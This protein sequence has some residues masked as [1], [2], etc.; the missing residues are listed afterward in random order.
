M[1]LQDLL[2][3]MQTDKETWANEVAALSKDQL[4]AQT[5]TLRLRKATD[6][7]TWAVLNEEAEG[8]GTAKL[9]KAALGNVEVRHAPPCGPAANHDL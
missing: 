9:L 1:Y 4:T 2:P 5:E 3:S 6:I 7:L 8:A